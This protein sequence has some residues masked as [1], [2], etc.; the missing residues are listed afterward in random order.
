MKR[1]LAE[2]KLERKP[3][4]HDIRAAHT[5]HLLE[6]NIPVHEVQARMGH[7]DP[8]TTLKIYARIG[9]NSGL[10]A[11]DASTRLDNARMPRTC[12]DH[13][14]GILLSTSGRGSDGPQRTPPGWQV[15]W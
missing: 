8:K 1:L 6:K 13:V 2:E 3:R 14:R 5:T 4:I 12:S 9:K 11:A 7:E 15:P 10:A